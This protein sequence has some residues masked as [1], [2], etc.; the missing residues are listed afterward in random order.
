MSRPG[1]RVRTRRE[2]YAHVPPTR[3]PPA[4]PNTLRVSKHSCPSCGFEVDRDW[5]A[6]FNIQQRGW[7]RLGMVHSEGTPAETATATDTL[8]VSASRVVETGSPCLNESAT[9]GE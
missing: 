8:G 4:T 9:A 3:L 5:N 7:N 1:D 2:V 6:A